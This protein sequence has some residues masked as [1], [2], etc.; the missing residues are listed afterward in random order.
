MSKE[1]ISFKTPSIADGS[2]K[3]YELLK[4][5]ETIVSK[6]PDSGIKKS[7]SV[8]LETFQKKVVSIVKKEQ[9]AKALSAIR[10]NPDLLNSLP[11]EVKASFASSDENIAPIIDAESEGAI[12]NV[13]KPSKKNK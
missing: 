9:I 6:M 13:K 1:K 8:T 3:M 11:D 12:S 4:N 10:K 5:I 2:K 7:Y